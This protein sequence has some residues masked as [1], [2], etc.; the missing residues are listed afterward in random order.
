MGLGVEGLGVYFQVGSFPHVSLKHPLNSCCGPK[1]RSE[2]P[3]PSLG[4][5]LHVVEAGRLRVG[6]TNE[7]LRY[8]ASCFL[9]RYVLVSGYSP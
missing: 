1:S 6:S 5:N 2:A 3:G 8:V 7:H 4:A 9:D